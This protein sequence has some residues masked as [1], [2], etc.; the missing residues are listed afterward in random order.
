MSQPS[1]RIAIA[2]DNEQYR[3]TLR[4]VLEFEPDLQVVALWSHGKEVLT[5]I[6]NVSPDIL[7]LDIHM[8]HMNGVET[9]KRLQDTGSTAKI[10]ILTMYDDAGYVLETLKSGAAG[11]LVK[12]G[13]TD[14]IIQAIRE[15]AAGRAMI[16]PQVAKTII[17]QFRDTV[18][19]S[20]SWQDILTSR[21]MDVLQQLACG[22]TNDEVA[23]ALHITVKTAKNHVS[24]I[25]FKLQVSDRTQAVIVAMK[26]RWVPA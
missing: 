14:E 22:K 21:E 26:E 11:Y 6:E 20:D 4:E 10:I 13:S 12:D 15:V 9:T 1:V 17:N 18:V 25:L 5:K 19:L 8:P 24:N 7:L 3:N 23:E 2:D 16:H